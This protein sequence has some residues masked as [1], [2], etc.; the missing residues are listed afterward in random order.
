MI[1]PTIP[2]K[3]VHHGPYLEPGSFP[4]DGANIAPC[5]KGACDLC[6]H[7]TPTRKFTSPWDKRKWNIRRNVTCTSP[8]VIYLIVCH[9]KG[10]EE[11]SWYVGSAVDMRNRWRNHK[12]DFLARRVTKCGFSQ[13]SLEAHPEVPK[14]NPLPYIQVIFLES[15]RNEDQLLEREIWWQTNIGTIF[16]GLNKRKDTRSIAIQ[17]NRSEIVS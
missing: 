13:H 3:F 14:F 4:C 12:S 7:V 5:T 17:R 8:N 1:K 15:L 10:H 6:K 9:C 16:F 2:R 11:T